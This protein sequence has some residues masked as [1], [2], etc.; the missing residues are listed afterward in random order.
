MDE[1]DIDWV[2]T[3][4]HVF[5]QASN[6]PFLVGLH[7]CFQTSSRWVGR[8]VWVGQGWGVWV[9]QGWIEMLYK[10]WALLQLLPS[11]PLPLSSLL[12]P[13]LPFL[14]PPS[15]PLL[16]PSSSLTPVPSS[17]LPLP[18]LLS[19]PPLLSS[20]PPPLPSPCRLFFVI[21]CVN[22]GD[23]MYHMQRHRRLPEEHARFYSAEIS[24]ALN[25][26]HERGRGSRVGRG[27]AWGLT[28]AA[29]SPSLLCVLVLWCRHHLP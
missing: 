6:H 22:G 14:F 4:K 19:P 18:S 29:S 5:E 7:S 24:L 23:L 28:L 12:S 11:S 3:E 13:P 20:S 26:L 9:G 21:E 2:Q 17:P 16:S 10:G 8:G 25:Y 15:C 1:E 27:E